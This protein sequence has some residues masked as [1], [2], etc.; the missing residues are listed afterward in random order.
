MPIKNQQNNQRNRQ[1]RKKRTCR[2]CESHE[3]YIDYKN[4]K[5]LIRCISEQGRIIP[6]RI[7][8]TCAKHQRQL[9]LAIKRARHLGLLPFVNDAVS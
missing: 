1:Q 3:D 6:R 7:T 5:R 2:F 8:G 9:T 4:E